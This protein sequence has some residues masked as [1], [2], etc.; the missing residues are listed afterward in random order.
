MVLKYVI[1]NLRQSLCYLSP[2]DLY[3][4]TDLVQD[5]EIL[6]TMTAAIFVTPP[7]SDT[8]TLPPKV[9]SWH[10][11]HPVRTEKCSTSMKWFPYPCQKIITDV[12]PG[13]TDPDL[14]LDTHICRLSTRHR[15]GTT[16]GKGSQRAFPPTPV[17]RWPSG[18]LSLSARMGSLPA[19]PW[20]TFTAALCRLGFD[21]LKQFLTNTAILTDTADHL[22]T[23]FALCIRAVNNS[24]LCQFN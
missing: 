17:T 6:L 9:P 19:L 13:K 16:T 3:I 1:I 24:E 18:V 14:N 12:P 15:Y 10:S 4:W 23:T 22:N 2:S 21:I 11:D 20:P 8:K 7:S 5:V